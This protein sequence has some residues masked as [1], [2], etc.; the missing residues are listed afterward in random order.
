MV[1]LWFGLR[2]ETGI[3]PNLA[4]SCGLPGRLWWSHNLGT[5]S[6]GMVWLWTKTKSLPHQKQLYLGFP[7]YAFPSCKKFE[8]SIVW[9]KTLSRYLFKCL[10]IIK[11]LLIIIHGMRY[12]KVGVGNSAKPCHFPY[13]IEPSLP[14]MYKP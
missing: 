5:V 3:E 14:V 12:C 1:R 7:L 4:L 13:K 10:K 11:E 8:K 9:S 2:W 6:A